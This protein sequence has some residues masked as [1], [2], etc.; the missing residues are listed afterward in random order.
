MKFFKIKKWDC[1]V[2]S[3]VH[4]DWSTVPS[5]DWLI[6]W[7]IVP[8]IDLPIDWSI[9]WLFHRLIDS[10]FHWL[11]DWLV[12]CFSLF[13]WHSTKNSTL[14]AF[15]PQNFQILRNWTVIFNLHLFIK[16]SFQSDMKLCK[17]K[18]L[19]SIRIFGL[20]NFTYWVTSGNEKKHPA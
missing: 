18:S 17:K 15:V 11:I 12:D 8:S 20:R 14:D 5:L 10:L 9:D 7:L 13:F 6:D 19:T 3:V 4:S 1:V 16:V 2:W